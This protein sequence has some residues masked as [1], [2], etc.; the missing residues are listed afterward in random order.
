LFLEAF[1]IEGA[2]LT[3]FLE[4]ACGAFDKLSDVLERRGAGRPRF[5]S[6]G[7]IAAVLVKAWLGRSY[8]DV[9]AYLY[10]NKETLVRF[11]LVVPDHNTIWRT[12]TFLPESYL[13]ELNHEICQSLKRGNPEWP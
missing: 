10:D 4:A 11:N 3:A 6:R 8:R 9:E 1:V 2:T 5:D 13:K 7:R 12:M